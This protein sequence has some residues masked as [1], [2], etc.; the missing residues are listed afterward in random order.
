MPHALQ[1]GEPDDL[2]PGA[3]A[4]GPDA[5]SPRPVDLDAVDRGLVNALLENGRATFAD[6]ARQ[7]GLSAPSVQ[8]RVRRLEDRG[9]IGGYRAQVSA[10]QVGLEVCALV[11]IELSDDAD[12]G[13]VESCLER[14]PEVED[15]WFVAGD[16]AY[17]LMVR[18]PDVAGLSRTLTSMRRIR[19]VGRTRTTV[20]LETQWEGRAQLLPPLSD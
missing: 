18:V 16:D 10:A 1:A 19:G 20:V 13:H 5:G 11:S 2:A 3:V 15:C 6:L 12:Q 7:V 8:D 4:P 14:L 9:V 17:V